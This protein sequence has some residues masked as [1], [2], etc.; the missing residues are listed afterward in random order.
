[1]KEIFLVKVKV[2]KS[3]SGYKIL[4]SFLVLLMKLVAILSI[5]LVRSFILGKENNI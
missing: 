3:K 1:M 5:T 4:F 2:L